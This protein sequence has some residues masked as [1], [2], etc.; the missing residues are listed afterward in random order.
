MPYARLPLQ[1]VPGNRVA[2]VYAD[3]EI[4][5]MGFTYVL[6]DG[7]EDTIPVDA[8]LEYNRD[9]AYLRDLLVHRLTVQAVERLEAS[10][11]S[12]REVIRRLGT[13]ASQFYRLLDPTN[14]SKTIDAM[15][16]LLTALGCR[17]EVRVDPG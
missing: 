11:L 1:P 5:H 4:G 13:S 17:V 7:T 15:V 2:E 10:G 6:E 14:T 16:E 3:A 12:H 9:P 8:V